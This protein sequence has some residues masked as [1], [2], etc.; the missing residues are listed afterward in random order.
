MRRT[1]SGAVVVLAALAAAAPAPAATPARTVT[2]QARSQVEQA[3]TVDN[4]PAGPSAGDLLVFTERLLDPSGKEIGHD[5]AVCVTLF[6]A[7]SLCTGTYD[8]RGGQVM[9]QLLQPGPQRTYDQAITGG[10]G[11]YA[12]ARGTVTVHQGDG[13]DR[14]TFRIRLP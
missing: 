7:R 8:L 5:A 3:Q 12:G 9:V 1:G 6:D 10:T 2:L 14:F 4:Q 11:R 13:G